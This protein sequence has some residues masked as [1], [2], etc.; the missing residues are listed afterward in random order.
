MLAMKEDELAMFREEQMKLS[1]R[2]RA[3]IG[4]E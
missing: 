1:A 2:L 3:L 4:E